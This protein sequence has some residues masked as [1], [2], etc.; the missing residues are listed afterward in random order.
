MPSVQKTSSPEQTVTPAPQLTDSEVRA[1]MERVLKKR[2][3]EFQY[4]LYRAQESGKNIISIARTGSGKTLTYFMPL[5]T[6]QDGIVIIVTALNVLGD[7][8]ERE[9][10]AAGFTAKSINGT[11]ESDEIFKVC[12]YLRMLFPLND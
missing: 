5:V 2:P 12:Q 4:K 11:N 3:C 10:N 7:Q 9:A 1:E 6:S 8:F